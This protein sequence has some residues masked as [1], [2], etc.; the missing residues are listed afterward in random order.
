MEEAL[1]EVKIATDLLRLSDNH[2]DDGALLQIES[3]IKYCSQQVD[4]QDAKVAQVLSSCDAA[5]VFS[6]LMQTLRAHMNKKSWPCIMALRSACIM[7][8][9]TF[10]SFCSDLC[11]VGFLTV[12]LKELKFYSRVH[13]EGKVSC[14]HA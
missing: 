7:L 13:L 11:S 4:G 9:N 12:L 10:D 8:T 3:A 14:S 1:Q 2:L 6:D 5:S